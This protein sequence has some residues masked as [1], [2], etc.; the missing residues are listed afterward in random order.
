MEVISLE[1]YMQLQK[2]FSFNVW[3]RQLLV[4]ISQCMN[5]LDGKQLAYKD[6]EI[7]ITAL[8]TNSINKLYYFSFSPLLWMLIRN[9]V[10]PDLYNSNGTLDY[11]GK[12]YKGMISVVI[13][14]LG[15]F[16]QRQDLDSIQYK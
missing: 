2:L 8:V 14:K 3:F 9:L 12:K 15:C 13:I 7:S 1:C 11:C 10:K 5:L 4:V 6:L 16:C